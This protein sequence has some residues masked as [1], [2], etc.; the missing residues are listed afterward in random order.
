MPYAPRGDDDAPAGVER[1]QRQVLAQV[2]AHV[3]QVL[4]DLGALALAAAAREP[5][6]ALRHGGASREHLHVEAPLR[7]PEVEAVAHLRPAA[8]SP[9][10]LDV[11][12]IPGLRACQP[13]VQM[14]GL[15]QDRN[16]RFP[17]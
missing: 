14:S 15:L 10:E 6:Q 9:W 3:A 16:V 2:L 4:L 12:P 5:R 1:E 8:G 13:K 17:C 11:T 7:V